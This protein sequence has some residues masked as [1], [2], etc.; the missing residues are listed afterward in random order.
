M[1]RVVA[2]RFKPILKALW[3]VALRYHANH[4]VR[5]LLVNFYLRC[6]FDLETSILRDER[7]ESYW[8]AW[9]RCG[10]LCT[11][12]HHVV[13]YVEMNVEKTLPLPFP[14]PNDSDL[15]LQRVRVRKARYIPPQYLWMW[16]RK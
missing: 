13:S 2:A 3:L 11:S 8:N 7:I 12:I 1:V 10:K 15:F 4:D 14:L 6:Q 5:R 16:L 9:D